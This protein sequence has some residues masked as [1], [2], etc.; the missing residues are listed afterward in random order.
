[1][2]IEKVVF[3][4]IF[5][6]TLK[7]DFGPIQGSDSGFCDCTRASTREEGLVDTKNKW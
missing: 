5:I 2:K 3:S 7:V 6:N 1:M 4:K